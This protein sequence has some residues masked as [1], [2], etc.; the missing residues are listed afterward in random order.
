[1]NTRLHTLRNTLFSSVGMYTEFVLGMLTSIVIARHLGPESFG[2]YSALI[3][4]I[5]LGI[6]VTNSG[7]ASTMI[8]FIAEARGAGRPEL[9]RTLVAQ[10]RRTQ[11]RY[12]LAVVAA[13]SAAL[14]LFGAHLGL[15]S[16]IP[17]GWLVAFF[18]F[19]V[20][21]R[22]TYMLNIGISKGMEDFRATA[23]V[24]VLTSPINLALI[25]LVAWWGKSLAWYL[26]VFAL[27]SVAFWLFSR[28]Q[29]PVG[30][31]SGP[32][33]APL[34]DSMTQ[35]LRRQVFYNTLIVSTSFLSAS[36]V[37]VLL[38]NAWGLAGDA[39][40]FKVAQGLAYGAASLVP[41]VFGA[42]MLPMMSNALS[43]DRASAGHRFAASTSYLSLLAIP[44]ALA[45]LVFGPHLVT[46]LYGPQYAPAA[47]MF[48]VF[49]ICSCLIQMAAAASGMLIGADRQRDIFILL[50]AC[51][52]L[53]LALGTL[54]IHRWGLHGA[55]ASSAIV[56]VVNVGTYLIMARRECGVGLRWPVLG[57]I[58]LAS[59]LSTLLAW[60]VTQLLP[61]WPGLATAAL[62]FCIAYALLT[63]QLGCWSRGDVDLI[64]HLLRGRLRLHGGLVDNTLHWAAARAQSGDRA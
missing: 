27:V 18:I 43:R 50:A 3:W 57:R 10:L 30:V 2:V 31:R 34:P 1:M 17:R 63:V 28:G 32:A 60:A 64:E 37:E 61:G 54:F 29:V 9:M 25:V 55:V 23:V 5:G 41:G 56:S 24:A 42:L 16:D 11:A 58:A 35:R 6:C 53:K 59:L 40:Q 26:G 39:G 52:V 47:L 49:L 45:G 33:Q 48:P 15:G 8:K 12:L 46:L 22:A 38:L 62:L 13:G 7:T 4:L 44:L 21:L 36:E 14:L 20:A 51:L 19:C